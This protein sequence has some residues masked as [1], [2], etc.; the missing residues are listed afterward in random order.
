VASWA[1]CTLA[2]TYDL[3]IHLPLQGEV[4]RAFGLTPVTSIAI[5]MVFEDT[6][7][8]AIMEAS[9]SLDQYASNHHTSKIGKPL[10]FKVINHL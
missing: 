1:D 8:T 10:I 6:V 2:T 3:N 4:C 5:Q 7:I 9:D